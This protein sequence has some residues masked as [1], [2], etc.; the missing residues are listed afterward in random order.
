LRQTQSDTRIQLSE[1]YDKMEHLQELVSAAEKALDARTEAARINLEQ[2][3]Q[4]EQLE[5]A[6]ANDS[7]API[8]TKAALLAAKLGCC[9][10]RTRFNG[11]WEN[12]RG[13][14][15]LRVSCDQIAPENVD[16]IVRSSRVLPLDVWRYAP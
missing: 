1:V 16:V 3:A 14:R 12:V 10:F 6:A 7:A 5:S 13:T 11:C 8:D 15:Q 2:V 4:N 9:L